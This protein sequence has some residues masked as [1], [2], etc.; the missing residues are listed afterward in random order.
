MQPVAFSLSPKRGG[1]H[2]TRSST[3]L[4]RLSAHHPVS[5]MPTGVPAGRG[6]RLVLRGVL[7]A[8]AHGEGSWARPFKWLSNAMHA[9]WSSG[10]SAR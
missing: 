9:S 4:E 7:R 6:E 1:K 3:V 5:R 10:G 8:E 2:G